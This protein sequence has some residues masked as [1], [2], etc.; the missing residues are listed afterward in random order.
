MGG[1]LPMAKADFRISFV[2]TLVAS[3]IGMVTPPGGFMS[4]VRM[5]MSQILSMA[6]R[7]L[8]DSGFTTSVSRAN[9]TNRSASS[10]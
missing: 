5:R 8:G 7:N 1:T 6:K 3:M 2:R 4:G 9:T 10:T